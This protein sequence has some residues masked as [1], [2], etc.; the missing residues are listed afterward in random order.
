MTD[1]VVILVTAS[2]QSEARRIAQQLV[3]NRLAACVSIVPRVESVYRWQGKI[4]QDEESQL[5]IKSK[6]E[7][8]AKIKEAVAQLH[9][10]QNPEIICLAINAGSEEY[11]RWIEE[12]VEPEP[13]RGEQSQNPGEHDGG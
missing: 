8:F 1:K 6:Y 3:E 9:S 7:L 4:V 11:L 12:S 2:S 10:Y 5:F 13:G